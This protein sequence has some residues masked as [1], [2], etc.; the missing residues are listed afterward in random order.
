MD[1]Q[2]PEQV[3]KERSAEFIRLNHIRMEEYASSFIG[4]DLEILVEEELREGEKRYYTGHSREYLTVAVP[5]EERLC[6]GDIVR[7]KAARS[8]GEDL[9]CNLAGFII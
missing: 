5:Y 2:L 1:G 6:S 3:K 7:V 9:H 4:K 8:A